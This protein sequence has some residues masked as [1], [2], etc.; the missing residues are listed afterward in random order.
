MFKGEFTTGFMPV[1]SNR[2]QVNRRFSG[3]YL[4]T[5]LREC[6]HQTFLRPDGSAAFVY[7]KHANLLRESFEGSI[8]LHMPEHPAGEPK[9][10]DVVTG[11]VYALNAEDV[12]PRIKL[13]ILKDVVTIESAEDPR[14]GD[15]VYYRHLPLL[16]RPLALVF[17]DFCEIE[18]I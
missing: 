18:K 12:I 14:P 17:G 4:D 16:D 15:T 8:S 6:Y 5:T 7:W 9:L 2:T 3:G 11:D 1:E 13:T 10:V